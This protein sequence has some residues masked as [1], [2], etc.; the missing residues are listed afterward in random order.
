M[1]QFSEQYTMRNS[2]T[3]KQQQH[4]DQCTTDVKLLLE[5]SSTLATILL[6][7]CTHCRCK[8]TIQSIV[9]TWIKVSYIPIQYNKIKFKACCCNYIDICMHTCLHIETII[10]QTMQQFFQAILQ[11]LIHLGTWVLRPILL[12]KVKGNFSYQGEQ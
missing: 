12:Y 8:K 6:I 1:V 10:S 5:S 2:N 11:G 7:S 4:G 3:K 9:F